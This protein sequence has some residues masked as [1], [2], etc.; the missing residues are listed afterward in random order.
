MW[1]FI[2]WLTPAE[3]A[4]GSEL[5]VAMEWRVGWVCVCAF[6]K[7][8]EWERERE[9]KRERQNEKGKQRI[10]GRKKEGDK[11]RIKEW[12]ELDIRTRKTY[13]K[14]K[15]VRKE[16]ERLGVCV[17]VS[18]REKETKTETEREREKK[19][20]T[21]VERWWLRRTSVHYRSQH[22]QCSGIT[23]ILPLTITKCSLSFVESTLQQYYS[24]GQRFLSQQQQKTD[25]VDW[26]WQKFGSLVF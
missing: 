15:D 11:R 17:S 1:H 24:T 16:R 4:A 14:K 19:R 18:K 26:I 2:R 20:E 25:Q 21:D 13:W 7:N 10:R 5:K 3:E 6:L 23:P 8:C 9:R 12:N 22:W